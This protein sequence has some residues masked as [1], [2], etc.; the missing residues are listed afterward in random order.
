MKLMWDM[1]FFVVNNVEPNHPDITIV[2]NINT[3]WA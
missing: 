1:I 2:H 3:N